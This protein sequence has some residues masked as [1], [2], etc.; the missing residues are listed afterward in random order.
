MIVARP[1]RVRRA[2]AIAL[3]A[4]LVALGGGAFPAA[5][6]QDAPAELSGADRTAVI[7]RIGSMLEER[8]VFADVA[9]ETAAHLAAELESGVFDDMSDPAAFASGLTEAI[10]QVT[11]DK[12]IRVV[13]RRPAQVQMAEQNPAR[14]MAEQIARQ[15]Q[16]NWGFERVE[17]L[18]GNV[19]YIDMRYFAGNPEARATASAAMNFLGNVDAIIFD[20]RRNGGGSP[21]MI[22]YISSYLFDEPTHLNSLYWR[23]GDRTDEF[24]TLADVP[25]PR[26]A[27]TPVFVLTS[28][29]TFSGAEE[30]SYNLKTRKRATIVGETTGGGA[31][32]GGT[33]PINEQFA[34]FI[35][36]GR[37]INPITGDNWEGT[38]V[39]PD[40]AVDADDAY[41]TALELAIAAAEERR[42]RLGAELDARWGAFEESHQRAVAL[43]ESG[44][45]DGAGA[46]MREALSGAV[47]DGLLGEPDINMLGYEAMQ[48]DR[49]GLAI[50]IFACNV[51]LFPDSANVYDSLA[52]AYMHDGQ[53]E[54]AIRFYT[55]SLELD[56][57]NE[58]A[59]TMLTQLRER[60]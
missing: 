30:F 37:A 14:A 15:R 20:M 40:I 53:T 44:D 52:E 57:G 59:K 56:P 12:H 24:W 21:E 47:E 10:Q 6:V 46:A 7:E 45:M 23:Q 35:P 8:Y 19:G 43:A 42:T 34:V 33:V 9:A 29:Y 25:G 41:D 1:L 31:N 51:K 5:A 49:N 4:V 54:Q 17:R 50:A 26:L 16:Q 28:D 27:D 32:P 3:L 38:G 36:T 2:G 39:A 18:E 22:R 60:G 55:R 11:H 13:V 48:R 58:N